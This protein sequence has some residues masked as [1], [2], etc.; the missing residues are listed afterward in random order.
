MPVARKQRGGD[1]T[2]ADVRKADAEFLHVRELRQ[3]VDIGVLHALGS[4]VGRGAAESL[5]ACD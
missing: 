3:R 4:R 5:R 1:E 2:R